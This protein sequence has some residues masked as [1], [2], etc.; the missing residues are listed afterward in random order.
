MAPFTHTDY[1]HSS[2]RTIVTMNLGGYVST[3]R[4]AEILGIAV[5]SVYVYVYRVK[6][7]PQP[8]RVGRTLLFEEA[9]LQ[10]WRAAHPSKKR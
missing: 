9:A 10:R 5:E 2:S 3:T 6:G 4:A 8:V 7:F 1:D